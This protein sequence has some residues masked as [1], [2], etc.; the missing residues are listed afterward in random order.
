SVTN[1]V[2]TNDEAIV[3]LRGL[4]GELHGALVISGNVSWNE[5]ESRLI[6]G[7]AHQLGG[8]LE[9][10]Q[11]ARRLAQAEERKALTLPQT[12]DKGMAT[13]QICPTCGKCYDHTPANCADDNSP[14]H[15]YR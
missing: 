8:A 10:Q 1:T 7:F 13:L 2:V 4:S 15:A 9:T 12:Q 11:M 6:A 5:A 14:L 3:P